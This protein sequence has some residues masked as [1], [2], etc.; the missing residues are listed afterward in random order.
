MCVEPLVGF[1]RNRQV[2]LSVTS[3]LQS[4]VSSL[5]V[6]SVSRIVVRVLPQ[7]LDQVVTSPYM[8]VIVIGPQVGLPTQLTVDDQQL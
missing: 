2:S 1:S 6:G 7:V 5:F 8:P 4:K 3:T